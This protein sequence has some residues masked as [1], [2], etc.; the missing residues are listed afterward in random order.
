MRSRREK[1]EISVKKTVK[2]EMD[3][4]ES[5]RGKPAEKKNGRKGLFF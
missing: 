1:K 5:D 4:I 2:T 3:E